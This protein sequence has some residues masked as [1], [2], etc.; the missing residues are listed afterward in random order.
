M[1][2]NQERLGG[3]IAAWGDVILRPL[4]A[5]RR[6][7]LLNGRE[8]RLSIWIDF[9]GDLFRSLQ[10][11]LP[12]YEITGNAGFIWA[13][14]WNVTGVGGLR[15]F[16]VDPSALNNV[17]LA[18]KLDT[19]AA[20]AQELKRKFEE[21]L[22]KAK[23]GDVDAARAVSGAYLNGSGVE[24][25]PG[26]ASRWLKI[27]ADKGDTRAQAQLA[28]MMLE[29]NGIQKD[30]KAALELFKSVAEKNDPEA[31]YT[32][33]RIY[34]RADGVEVNSAEAFAWFE[35]AA[36]LGSSSARDRIEEGQKVAEA[37]RVARNR[38]EGSLNSI[39]AEDLRR[40]VLDQ[41]V[42]LASA[43]ARMSY[44]ELAN[45]RQTIES[46]NRQITELDD[47]DRVSNLANSLV[48]EVEDELRKITSDAPLMNQL[49]L[50]IIDVQKAVG[51]QD[52]ASLQ[53]AM[54]NLSRLYKGNLARLHAMEFEAP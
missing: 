36:A 33:G 23:S 21:L 27:L 34:D 48:K 20:K 51:A 12:V 19:N 31:A 44:G 5:D 18:T 30:P 41:S 7:A 17:G 53:S 38:L 6:E 28:L 45:T 52:L 39:K 1:P 2:E 40:R 13:A 24:R 35:K 32:V 10:L 14:S 43:N 42:A 54:G 25:S 47:L 11:G 22:G 4:S 50:G 29:G 8:V 49:R 16:A 3:M 26:E 15:F 9:L 37:A 46:A